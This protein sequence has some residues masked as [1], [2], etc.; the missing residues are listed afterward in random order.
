[1]LKLGVR[2]GGEPLLPFRSS[3]TSGDKILITKSFDD[4]LYRLLLIRLSDK[5]NRRGAV[6]TGQPG[7]GV[8]V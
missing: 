2:Q 7:I 1:M 8:S 3:V 5:G 6:L 4:M